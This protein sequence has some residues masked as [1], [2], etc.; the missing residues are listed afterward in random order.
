MDPHRQ[1]RR[2]LY[3]LGLPPPKDYTLWQR[4][5][6]PQ[7]PTEAQVAQLQEAGQLAQLNTPKKREIN[8]GT[9]SLAFTLPRQAVSF[10]V[11]QQV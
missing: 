4:M 7:S 6:E 10:L 1:I 8:R 11:L 3:G 9:A 5:G 2:Y